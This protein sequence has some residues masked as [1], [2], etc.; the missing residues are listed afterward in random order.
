MFSRHNQMMGVLY[1]LADGVLAAAS[2]GLAHSLRLSLASLRP[3]YPVAYY[4]WIF[5]FVVALWL[6]TGWA[7]GLYRDVEE[8]DL[9]RT[10]GGTLKV[11]V[12][13][14]VILFAFIFAFKVEFISRLL[15][16]FYALIDFLLMS[17]FRLAANR[18]GGRISASVAGF[19]Q[20]LLV[21]NTP[22][23][24]EIAR[25]IEANEHRGMR[26]AGFAVLASTGHRQP[27]VDQSGLRHRYSVF[28]LDQLPELLRRHVIDEVIF[29]VNRDE[30]DALE[31]TFLLC[32]QEGVKTRLSLNFF[33]HIISRMSFE[34]LREMPL[35][36]FSTTPENQYFMLIKRVLDFFMAA[37]LVIALSP[38][39]ITLAALI[40]LTSKG[41]VFYRQTRCG[42]GGRKFTLYKFRSMRSDA[43]LLKEELRALNEMDGPVFKIKND[44]RCTPIGR[45]MR[46]MSWDEL[47]QLFNILKGDMS[48]VGPRP[49][50]PEE[51]ER[52]ERWQRRR[53]RMQPGLTCLWAL[54][55]RSQLNFKRWMELDL[56]YIDHWS[57]MLD[58]KILLKT[59]PVVLLGR[60]AF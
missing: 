20:F 16:V 49:P 28:T 21:G 22:Q 1:A 13:A 40:K 48:F 35:L 59:I 24:L 8:Q 33:P 44:P 6:A 41:P 34:R 39:L 54:E 51:V 45:L 57:P 56:E 17:L 27:A 58:C 50:L 38:L 18:W 30:L 55:G 31:N 60:G 4:F 9:R 43:D 12:I 2:F 42:L 37:V 52:Y 47:P 5:P 7:T 36:T 14:T 53:L 25:I 11:A 10:L 15:L 23:A 46:R 26:L 19:S 29:A 32:E 3:L